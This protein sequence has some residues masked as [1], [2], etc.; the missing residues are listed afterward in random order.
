MGGGGISYESLGWNVK[1]FSN[2]TLLDK[3]K[4]MHVLE[5]VVC[6]DARPQVEVG[7]EDHRAGA[8]CHA[9]ARGRV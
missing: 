5:C 4:L 1:L 8:A 6:G 7:T 3:S 2:H 9:H